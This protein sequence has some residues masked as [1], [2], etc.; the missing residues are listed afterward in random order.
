MARSNVI[1]DAAIRRRLRRIER[2]RNRDIKRKIRRGEL[3]G[4]T[5]ELYLPKI[6]ADYEHIRAELRNG[7]ESASTEQRHE[8]ARL[9]G[10]VENDLNTLG[11]EA[12]RVQQ[13]YET[14]QT[15]A[16]DAGLVP[17]EAPEEKVTIEHLRKRFENVDGRRS[18]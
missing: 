1:T 12:H 8:R 2:K 10:Q 16:R 3:T 17:T 6:A 9:A 5:L 13:A 11:N 18:Q 4:Q 14:L 7:L 15:L